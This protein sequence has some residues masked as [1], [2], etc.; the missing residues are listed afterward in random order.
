MHVDSDRI[1]REN[2]YS[3]DIFYMQQVRSQATV[4]GT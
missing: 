4:I 3:R 1:S 2:K